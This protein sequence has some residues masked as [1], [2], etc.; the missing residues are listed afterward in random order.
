MLVS[1]KTVTGPPP[2]PGLVYVL[3]RQQTG[4][5]SFGLTVLS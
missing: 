4:P 2:D 3:G 1:R 5:D